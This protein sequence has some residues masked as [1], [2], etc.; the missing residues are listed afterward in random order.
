MSN[1]AAAAFKPYRPRAIRLLNAL[2]RSLGIQAN[3]DVDNLLAAARK[4]SGYEQF[5][6]NAFMPA[7]QKLLQSIDDEANLHPFGRWVVRGRIIHALVLRARV[8]ALIEQNPEI[9]YED[10]K[11]PLVIAG[12]Q[13][14]GTT[15]LHR[16]LA[17]DPNLRSLKS[18]EALNPL[19]L[20]N[21]KADDPSP[22]LR[23]AR[24][25]ENGLKYLAPEFFKI[26]PVEAEAPEEDVLL[27]EYSF[28]SQ[29]PEAMYNVPAYANWL[30]TQ[31]HQPAY[32]YLKTL[33]QVLQ[34]SD[35]RMS[36]SKRWVLKTPAHLEQMDKLLQVFPDAKVIQT[37][38]DPFRT[39][40][41]YSSML[42]HGQGVFTDEV[43]AVAVARHWLDKNAAALAKT[44]QVRASHPEAFIDAWYDQLIKDPMKE[45]ERIYTF[46]GMELTEDVRSVMAASRRSNRKDK[47]GK[48]SYKLE[49]F[50]LNEALI[51]QA[52]ADYIKV[53]D[54]P[55]EGKKT[56]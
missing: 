46:A 54:I 30:K 3:L 13:R 21:E 39:V 20:K 18:W 25:A 28:M 53:F 24:V 1:N 7:L 33:L 17:A 27:L 26:H 29:V 9:L 11:A 19:P 49:D 16:L 36:Q 48:H 51:R 50:G 37:H 2:C 22:R 44:N 43:D 4:K 14:T 47:H 55:Q 52:Y 23:E 35:G 45:V 32:E 42:A 41:S 56:A 34:W 6:D 5:G 10:I 8:H 12:L 40:G 15:M 31:D 38:R